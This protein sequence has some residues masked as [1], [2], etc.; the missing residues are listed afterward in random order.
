MSFALA[1]YPFF[2]GIVVN[3]QLTSV[4]VF[5]V[6]VAIYLE[7]RSRLFSS[8]LALSVLA[9]KPT[10]LLLLVPMLL[11]TR[12]FRTLAGF[13]SGTAALMLVATAFGGIQIWPA[14]MHFLSLFGQVAGVNGQRVFQL[15]IYIDIGSCLQAVV[16][17]RSR[18]E[19]AIAI[20]VATT[21]VTGLAV[22]LWKSASGS[23]PAQSLAWAA[24]LTWTLLLNVYIPMYDSVLVVIAVVL[25]LGAVKDLAWST[26]MH[27]ITFLSIL[28]FAVS[29][30]TYPIAMNYGIQLISI[31]LAVLGLAQLYLLYRATGKRLPQNVSV[32]RAS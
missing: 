13:I 23:R 29:W 10:L 5:S 30:V 4:A 7:R 28:I 19:L 22:L 1:F 26:T 15:W 11:L 32:L 18:V 31:S 27:W 16:G 24:T 14:Y 25:T 6:G 2:W 21:I 17:G 8:G 20:P 9:Y 12:R 3:G